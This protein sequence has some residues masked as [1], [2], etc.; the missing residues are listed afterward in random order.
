[1]FLSLSILRAPSV[2]LESL[3]RHA[4]NGSAGLDSLS[5]VEL[6]RGT[7]LWMDAPYGL[8]KRL[9]KSDI[10]FSATDL[11][12][13]QVTIFAGCLLKL[14]I[15]PKP[16]MESL[17]HFIMENCQRLSQ[18]DEGFKALSKI[19][20]AVSNNTIA[21]PEMLECV[22]KV[23]DSCTAE[24]VC[25]TQGVELLWCC[26]LS[27][28]MPESALA[29]LFGCGDDVFEQLTADVSTVKQVNDLHWLFHDGLLL[30]EFVNGFGESRQLRLKER[31]DALHPPRRFRRD[32]RTHFKGAE[33]CLFDVRTR[34]NYTL[35]IAVL[36]RSTS[37]EFV[38]WD[39]A[40]LHPCE[41]TETKMSRRRDLAAEAVYIVSDRAYISRSYFPLA[42]ARMQKKVLS[43]SGWDVTFVSGNMLHSSTDALKKRLD[44][45]HLT[46]V[47]HAHGRRKSSNQPRDHEQNFLADTPWEK[48]ARIQRWLARRYRRRQDIQRM[49]KLSR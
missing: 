2:I 9:G 6:L 10:A 20:F 22:G 5:V 26:L 31:Y 40:K 1:M 30:P 46:A 32:W 28:V 44:D 15:N 21:S 43:R 24:R 16:W 33:C 8:A 27:D 41:V 4:L 35:D 12:D 49:L 7:M 45:F 36:R 23:L 14:R 29:L 13:E 48:P 17:E 38:G 34:E 11:T 3:V 39:N 42:W 18:S 25:S 37:F 19:V 47:L